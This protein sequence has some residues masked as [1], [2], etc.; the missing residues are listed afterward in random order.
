MVSKMQQKLG[1]LKV[2]QLIIENEMVGELKLL[3]PT[4]AYLHPGSFYN[5]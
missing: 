5:N 3:D 4:I 1:M 2:A